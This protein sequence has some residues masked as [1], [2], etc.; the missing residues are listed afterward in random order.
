MILVNSNKGDIVFN[1]F[2]G[3]G[4]TSVKAKKKLG[5]NFDRIE[6]NQQ[7]S[8][9]TEKRLEIADKDKTI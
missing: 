3:S 6:Q 8:V 4:L 7:Y 5:R 9:W 2:L 1:P